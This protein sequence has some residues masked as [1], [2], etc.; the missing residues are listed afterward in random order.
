MAL[1]ENERKGERNKGKGTGVFF[2][3]LEGGT[4]KRTASRWR[5]QV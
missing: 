1:I 3:E 2:Q 5:R 4:M